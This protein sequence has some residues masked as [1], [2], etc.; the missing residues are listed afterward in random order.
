M[1]WRFFCSHASSTKAL[2]RKQ[3]EF[4]RP[5]PQFVAQASPLEAF[6]EARRIIRQDIIELRGFSFEDSRQ[7][8]DRSSSSMAELTDESV[9]LVV[10]SPP[11]LNNFDFAEMTRMYL[12][13]WEL[14]SSWAEISD[15]V[16]SR[17]VVNT[18]TALRGQKERQDEYKRNIPTVLLSALEELVHELAT[19]R[20]TRAGKKEYDFLVYPY[21]SQ[22]ADIL[23]E[24]YRV[25]KHGAPIHVMI[26]DAALYGVH[27][28]APQLLADLLGDIGFDDVSCSLVRRRGHRWILTKREGSKKG[29]GEYHVSAKK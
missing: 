25:M 18:T 23:R 15:K 11:Y 24:C 27:V 17:L 29:L 8:H 4:T 7:V 3:M 16:R 5:R 9:G 6:S 26:A 14:A 22:M 12:Y 19:K 1:I 20:K 28:S 13:F 21:F 2:T 10:T